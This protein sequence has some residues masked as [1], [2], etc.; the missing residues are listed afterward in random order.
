MRRREGRGC[1]EG[2]REGGVLLPRAKSF[3]YTRLHMHVV[4][5]ISGDAVTLIIV[6]CGAHYLQKTI[7]ETLATESSHREKQTNK[8]N[9]INIEIKISERRRIPKKSKTQMKKSFRKQIGRESKKGTAIK[10]RVESPEFAKVEFL[11]NFNSF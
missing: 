5:T 11:F 8:K 4:F 9:K 3:L 6:I 10:L 2:G 1:R 7:K